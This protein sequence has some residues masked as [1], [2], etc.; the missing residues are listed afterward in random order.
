[1]TSDDRHS[2]ADEAVI[3]EDP[4]A[5]ARQEAAN[6]LRQYNAAMEVVRNHIN[7]SERPFR[8]RPSHVLMLNR[9]ALKGIER[10]AGAFRNTKIRIG[11]S[12]HVP[13]DFAAVPEEIE[14]MCDYVNEHWDVAPCHLGAYL[15]WRLNWI[16]PFVDGNGRTSRMVS[17]M[18]LSIRMNSLLP[19]VPTIPEQIS[20]NKTPYYD[21][22]EKAD[23]AWANGEQV[24]VS[25][26]EKLLEGM[27]AQQL[28]NATTAASAH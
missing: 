5:R 25:E 12:R 23:E 15:L 22:L 16:H 27:L 28:Y 21:A 7:D 13:P 19:G 17:Y 3:V 26:L 4:E 11:K 20:V 1:M 9:E 6:G 14:G 8:L 24:D 18:V 2:V 10:M